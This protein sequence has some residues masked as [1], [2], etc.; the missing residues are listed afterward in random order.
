[1]KKSLRISVLFQFIILWSLVGYP[2]LASITTAFGMNNTVPSMILRGL[3]A[4]AAGALLFLRPIRVNNG[5]V[6]TLFLLF[7]LAYFLR[8]T[9]SLHLLQ[10]P[11][12]GVAGNY[13]IWAVGASFLP[14]LAILLGF[15]LVRLDQLLPSL[16]SILIVSILLFIVFGNTFN[17]NTD[18]IISDINRWNTVVMNP[19]SMGHLGVTAVLVGISIFTIGPKVRNMRLLG[20][21]AV[22][23]GT[24]MAFLA[25][26]RGP[27]VALLLT[28]ALLFIARGRRRT[29]LGLGVV[30]A[31]SSVALLLLQQD[32]LFGAGGVLTRFGTIGSTED[33]SYLSRYISFN[34]AI[35]QFLGS[36]FFGDGIEERIT[37][38]YPHNVILEAFMA[39]GIIG[40]I[41]FLMLVLGAVHAAWRLVRMGASTAWVGLLAVQYI[42]GGLFSGAIY[43]SAVMWVCI[44]L[45][46][47]AWHNIARS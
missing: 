42:V 38:F 34:G 47:S 12:S 46:F 41:P 39:T 24:L 22:V 16:V 7:W 19:I 30:L 32:A 27:I 45:V 18:G 21:A 29:T 2:F 20:T 8:L 9:V 28:L 5:K 4:I 26:S 37:Q 1:M 14:S 15:N 44:A 11:T 13:W 23:L 35:N 6:L 33:L 40:G 17:I 36:P 3:V 31:L 10:E 43:Q 25:N